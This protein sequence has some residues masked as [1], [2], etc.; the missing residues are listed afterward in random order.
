[1]QGL[2]INSY[3]RSGL[4]GGWNVTLAARRGLRATLAVLL[5]LI[6]AVTS[7]AWQPPVARA[8]NSECPAQQTA[9][10]GIHARIDEHNS[11]LGGPGPPE[12]VI[13][14]NRE[15]DQLEAEQARILDS[16]HACQLAINKVRAG[17]PPPKPLPPRISTDLGNVAAASRPRWTAPT[18]PV[19]LSDGRVTIPQGHPLRPVWD[20]VKNQ[21][22]P[23]KPYPNMPLQGEP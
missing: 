12:I 11:R 4:L 5:L 19:N 17:G 1:M 18:A 21:V 10:D 7:G 20:I 15:A 23:M 8:D 14:Y 2:R 22:T 3:G 9:L 13:P 6:F 16:L